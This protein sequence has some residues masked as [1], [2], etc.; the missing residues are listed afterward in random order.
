MDIDKIWIGIYISMGIIFIISIFAVF[1]SDIIIAAL[2]R[3]K[4]IKKYQ[5]IN[6]FFS[7]VHKYLEL[8][9][10]KKERIIIFIL[11]ILIRLIKYIFVF[12]LFV[13][14]MDIAFD[15]S[16]FAK[17]SFALAGTEMSTLLPV[18]GLGG[19]GTWELAFKF[20]FENMNVLAKGAEAHHFISFAQVGII[21][22]IISQVWEYSIGILAFFIFIVKNSL[23]KK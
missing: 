8:H 15:I 22:H 16:V 4:I 5:K 10:D 2:I 23:Q 18:Q 14:I 6:V 20:V 11:S 19:F 17:F 7:N 21:I 3:L 13:A 9:S 1:C 12:V